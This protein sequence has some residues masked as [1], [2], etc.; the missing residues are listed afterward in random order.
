MSVACLINRIASDVSAACYRLADVYRG[1]DFLDSTRVVLETANECGG[2]PPGTRAPEITLPRVGGGTCSLSDY[3]GERVLLAFVRPGCQRSRDMAPELNRL[4]RSGALQVLAICGGTRHEAALWAD[5]VLAAFPVLC[6]SSQDDVMECD[7][8][9]TPCRLVIGEHGEIVESGV[10]GRGRSGGWAL[11]TVATAAGI[12][13][14]ADDAITRI[15][16][17]ITAA[18]V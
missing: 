18:Q 6:Q 7:V 9:Q 14:K 10:M 4:Q 15:S 8:P 12:R 2:L 3:R 16:T 17:L 13:Q 11:R 5:D 1:A